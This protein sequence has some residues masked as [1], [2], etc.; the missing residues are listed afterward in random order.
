MDRKTV[1]SSTNLAAH[2]TT[3]CHRT[4][5]HKN[6]TGH[7]NEYVLCTVDTGNFKLQE[8]DFKMKG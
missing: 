8:R 6:N 2:Q 4:E 7:I 5:K 1:G 3:R